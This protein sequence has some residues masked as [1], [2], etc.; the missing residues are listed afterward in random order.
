VKYETETRC[1]SKHRSSMYGITHAQADSMS[2]YLTLSIL[3]SP[4]LRPS[5]LGL[6]HPARIPRRSRT[7][8]SI[9]TQA[10]SLSG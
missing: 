2:T 5:L 6:K 8:Y 9:T 3:N 4:S 7:L 10:H 1:V